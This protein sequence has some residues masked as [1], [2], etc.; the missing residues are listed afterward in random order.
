MTTA[1]LLLVNLACQ[2]A[3]V[4]CLLMVIRNL[5]R[6]SRSLRSIHEAQGKMIEVDELTQDL[7]AVTD[8]RLTK[9][10]EKP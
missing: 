6:L 3:I 9:L 4:A 7:F 1:T 5:Q 10:E 2:V 8:K